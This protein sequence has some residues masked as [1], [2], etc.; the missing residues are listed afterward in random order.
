MM[1]QFST[2]K[3]LLAAD[4]SSL[5]ESP[6]VFEIA[7][8]VRNVLFIGLA[9]ESLATTLASH[10]DVPTPLHARVG[11]LY[12]RFAASDQAEAMQAELLARYR[13]QHAGTLPA[14]QSSAAEPPQ[15]P[16]RHLKAV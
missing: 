4:I 7:T 9:P 10:L 11:R 12:F 8:L 1:A 15:R 2:W 6:G 16:Q 13:E 3:P 5:P 14:A